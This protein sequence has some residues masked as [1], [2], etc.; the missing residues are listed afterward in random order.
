MKHIQN[1]DQRFAQ[2]HESASHA[3]ETRRRSL[4]SAL[5]K[6]AR[7]R[8]SAVCEAK[9]RKDDINESLRES[10]DAQRY[11]RRLRAARLK[12]TEQRGSKEKSR[13]EK[14][15]RVAQWR[16]E[17]LVEERMLK[18]TERLKLGRLEELEGTMLEKV[19]NTQL[20]EELALSRLRR[21]LGRRPDNYE[22]YR[23]RMVERRA[24]I[25]DM[26]RQSPRGKMCATTSGSVDS[27]P[28]GLSRSVAY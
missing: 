17:R 19:R 15:R 5:A 23:R 12:A 22:E 27:T 8:R 21:E 2:L 10:E 11:E 18:A 20:G 13:L 9:S 6:M 14:I 28:N 3:R 1:L 24:Q 4:E 25:R 7:R 16:E 26:I